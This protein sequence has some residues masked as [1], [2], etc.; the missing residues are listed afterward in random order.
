M[1]GNCRP[2]RR[3]QHGHAAHR[4]PFMDARNR[5]DFPRYGP[6]AMRG[7]QRGQL[8]KAGN[9]VVQQQFLHRRTV[10]KRRAKILA[11]CGS[12]ESGSSCMAGSETSSGISCWSRGPWA[13]LRPRA[14]TKL[15]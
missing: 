1:S 9:H 11:G 3:A 8:R 4:G 2:H 10:G 14:E 6:N 7:Q 15:S 5:H 13:S 12:Y